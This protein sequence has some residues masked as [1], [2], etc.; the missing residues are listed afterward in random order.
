MSDKAARQKALLAG[1]GL[2]LVSVLWYQFG[3]GTA[4]ASEPA[5]A[6]TP[7]PRRTGQARPAEAVRVGLDRLEAA[8]PAP[9]AGGRNPFRFGSAPP[10]PASA[11]GSEAPRRPVA[12]PPV[13]SVPTGPLPP[14]PPPPIPYKFI[15]LLTPSPGD[16]VAVL[17]DGRTV[18]HGRAGDVIDGRYRLLSVADEA[19]QMEYLDGRG[20]R[21]IR[22]SGA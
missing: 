4:P 9:P 13:A 1:L 12:A 2:V 6:G 18:V 15:G 7:P 10:P 16:K 11:A 21:V 20:R 19:V 3:L 5:A 22:L 8:R 17:S 14:P